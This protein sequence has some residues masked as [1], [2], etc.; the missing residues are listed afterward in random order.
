MLKL[1]DLPPSVLSLKGG[2]RLVGSQKTLTPQPTSAEVSSTEVPAWVGSTW[3]RPPPDGEIRQTPQHTRGKGTMFD[4]RFNTLGNWKF[5]SLKELASKQYRDPLEVPAQRAVVEL[6]RVLDRDLSWRIT[7]F[8][9]QWASE[10]R[11]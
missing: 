7:V 11:Y 3:E 6:G 10:P 2:T 1:P 9:V 8:Q 5:L 4:D